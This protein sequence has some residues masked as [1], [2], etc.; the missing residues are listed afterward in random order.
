MKVFVV[1][2]WWHW[3]A[4]RELRAFATLDKACE[5]IKAS[6]LY[7]RFR[8]GRLAGEIRNDGKLLCADEVVEFLR[9][10]G[11]YE[12]DWDIDEKVFPFQ[13]HLLE[14]EVK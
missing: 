6:L 12:N 8:D 10:K 14:K 5:F 2:I 7:Y 4:K 1:N 3:E 13:I 9:Q 11:F